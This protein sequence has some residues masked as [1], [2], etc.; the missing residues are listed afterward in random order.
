MGMRLM[1]KQKLGWRVAAAWGSEGKP[2]GRRAFRSH[3]DVCDFLTLHIPLL[4]DFVATWPS[5]S[6]CKPQALGKKYTY[7]FNICV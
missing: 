3:V 4:L 6:P 2:G 1:P 5:V 7:I